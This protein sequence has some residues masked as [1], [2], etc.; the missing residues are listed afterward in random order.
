MTAHSPPPPTFALVGGRYRRA[1]LK[2]GG[3]LKGRFQE[4]WQ[5]RLLAGGKRLQQL[6]IA[7]RWRAMGAGLKGIGHPFH[8]A[9]L[10]CILG[11]AGRHAFLAPHG[12][13]V[14]L[15]A[16]SAPGQ[17]SSIP[18]PPKGDAGPTVCYL[19]SLSKPDACLRPPRVG[20]GIEICSASLGDRPAAGNA[21]QGTTQA[22]QKRKHAEALDCATI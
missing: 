4:R 3:R 2:G 14:G 21:R 1:V 9:V 13:C 15:R 22:E 8:T 11:W 5:E 12:S 16:P 10:V 20:F 17:G 18:R 7:K 19:L 6:A